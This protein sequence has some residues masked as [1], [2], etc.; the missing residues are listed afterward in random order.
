MEKIKEEI[1]K[2][3]NVRKID[4]WKRII[5]RGNSENWAKENKYIRRHNSESLVG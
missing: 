5:E 1:E 2:S 3:E 4:R